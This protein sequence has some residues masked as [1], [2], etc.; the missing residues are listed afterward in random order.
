MAAHVSD[1]RDIE[2]VGTDEKL[3]GLTVHLGILEG[4]PTT[5]D[6]RPFEDGIGLFVFREKRPAGDDYDATDATVGGWFFLDSDLFNEV[7]SQVSVG[8]YSTCS[9]TVTI[10]PVASRALDWV[11]DVRT[12][13]KLVIQDVS[14]SFVREKT[15]PTE[16]P[17]P[18]R[19]LFR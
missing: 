19:G 4:E 9:I 15:K 7:W 17:P 3:E 5:G 2:L 13:N 16:A 10:G 6:G 1:G 14:V 8:R 11:W 12:A 18:K